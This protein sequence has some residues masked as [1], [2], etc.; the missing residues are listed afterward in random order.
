MQ[1]SIALACLCAFAG[2]CEAQTVT[3]LEP[4]PTTPSPAT[5]AE[6]DPQDGA[7]AEPGPGPAPATPDPGA[8]AAPEPL[9]DVEAVIT[10]DNAFSFGYG[11]SA[12]LDTFTQGE[13]SGFNEIFDCPVGF[14]PMPFVVPGEAAPEGAYLYIVAWAD[15]DW[16]QGV[17][18]QFR[19]KG[20]SEVIYSGNGAWEVCATGMEFD[21]LGQGPDHA[22]VNAQ[23]T[24]CNLGADGTSASKGWV[25]TSGP[26]TAGAIGNLAYGEAND[27]PAGDFPIVCQLDENGVEGISAEARWMWYDPEDGVSPFFGNAGNRTKGFL[28]FR[29][30]ADVLVVI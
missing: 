29:L 16:T 5:P 26:V 4:L 17:L 10:A 25:D 7:P 11:D 14:G 15:Q 12:G 30:P 20:S 13:A 19:R 24:Q 2:A 21:G 1:K 8:P 3:T 28:I 18:A 23:V 9:A 27:D 6:E 22:Q